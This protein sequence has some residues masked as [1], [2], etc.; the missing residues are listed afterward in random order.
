[1]RALA[2]A[3]VLGLGCLVCGA[4]A[5]KKAG[6]LPVFKLENE[7]VRR[8]VDSRPELRDRVRFLGF[9]ADAEL[10]GGAPAGRVPRQLAQ[11]RHR[12]AVVARRAD[13]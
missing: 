13:R 8:A 3:F 9:V 7:L 10:R 11:R 6:A 5:E 1:M 2:L 4:Q 12:H